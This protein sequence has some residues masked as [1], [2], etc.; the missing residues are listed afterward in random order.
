MNKKIYQTS[1]NDDDDCS[2]VGSSVSEYNSESDGPEV[3]SS[4]DN[5]EAHG[6]DE[7]TRIE[8]PSSIEACRIS[9]KAEQF[10]WIICFFYISPAAQLSAFRAWCSDDTEVHEDAVQTLALVTDNVL[11]TMV[12]LILPLS[13]YSGR[14]MIYL[15]T[16]M[17][18]YVVCT[19]CHALYDLDELIKVNLFGQDLPKCTIIYFPNHRQ[20]F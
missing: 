8:F 5:D 17:K 1:A 10:V 2:D 7:D 19:K 12:S 6:N 13:L 20:L 16:K 9:S 15:D 14:R 4:D 18:D 11:I 3:W